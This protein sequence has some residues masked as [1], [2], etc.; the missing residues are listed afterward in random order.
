MLVAALAACGPGCAPHRRGAPDP[1]VA[2]ATPAVADTL[3]LPALP[4]PE[5]RPT[6]Q[7]NA[8]TRSGPRRGG[9][10]PPPVDRIRSGY[11]DAADLAERFVGTPYRF[12][13]ASPRGFDCSGLV[14]Y[15]YR[16]FGVDLPRRAVDQS[17]SGRRVEVQSLRRSDL[18]FFRID[19]RTISHVGIYLGDGEFLHAPG[20]G[21]YVRV[22]SLENP[23]WRQ[24]LA[25]ARRID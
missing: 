13:G 7:L 15:V 14:Q 6:L 1:V 19:R 22:D 3:P 10:V 24:R 8:G 20:T 4:E 25:G 23:W 16:E 18:V 5:L 9:R 12:G 17:R 2:A 21:K 11:R